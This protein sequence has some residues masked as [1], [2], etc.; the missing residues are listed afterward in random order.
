MTAIANGDFV[1]N[2]RNP[3]Q[4]I[5]T[6]AVGINEIDS[7]LDNCPCTQHPGCAP[8]SF[9]SN[10][11]YYESASTKGA[12]YGHYYF[13]DIILLWMAQDVSRETTVV[14]TLHNLGS[15]VN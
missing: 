9:V 1:N 13:N 12:T 2:G 5:W 10:D 14:I 3:R 7:D 11:Y 6:C 15:I 4:H 8:P